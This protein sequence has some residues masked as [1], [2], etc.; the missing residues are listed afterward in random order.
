[1]K[2][3]R[4]GKKKSVQEGPKKKKRKEKGDEMDGI[5]TRLAAVVVVRLPIGAS[6]TRKRENAARASV[7]L[8]ATDFA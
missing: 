4:E 5:E 3:S 1:M 6:E 8:K 7:S 2:E